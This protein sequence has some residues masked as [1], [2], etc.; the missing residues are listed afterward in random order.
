M[1]KRV[2][3]V[4]TQNP[5][6][7]NAE[8]PVVEAA[9]VM[10]DEDVGSVPVVENGRLIGTLTDRDIVVRVVVERRDPQTTKVREVASSDLVIDHR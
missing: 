7:V 9:R 6:T 3:D 4:M 5:R 2:R 8:S 1:G 10:K